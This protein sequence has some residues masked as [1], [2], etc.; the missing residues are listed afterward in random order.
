MAIVS[1][2]TVRKPMWQTAVLFTLLFWLSGSLLLDTVVMP[3][4]YSSGMM[5]EPG[6]A[7]A[8]YSLFWVFNRV[9]LLCAAIVLTGILFRCNLLNATGNLNQKPIFLA[10][11]LFVIALVYTY[12]LAPQ[13]SSLGLQLSLTGSASEVPALMN[14]L[15]IGYWLL[16]LMK[17]GAGALL[18]RSCWDLSEET[19]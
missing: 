4:L 7:T 14:S 17:L 18:L 2:I 5:T 15:H 3:V 10:S 8:G 1:K 13:M 9:E 16:E 11:F 6:F 12:G 19:I